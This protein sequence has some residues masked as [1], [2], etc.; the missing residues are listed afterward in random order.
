MLSLPPVLAEYKLAPKAT[1][2]ISL[3]SRLA[4][5]VPPTCVPCASLVYL[6]HAP[7]ILKASPLVKMPLSVLSKLRLPFFTGSFLLIGPFPTDAS[8]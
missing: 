3:P 5:I 8:G 7:S 4:A 6:C 1:P 2:C